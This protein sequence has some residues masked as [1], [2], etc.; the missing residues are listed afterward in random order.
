MHQA[1]STLSFR[2]PIPSPLLPTTRFLL[3]IPNTANLKVGGNGGPCDPL[4][5]GSC[6]SEIVN[7]NFWF[8]WFLTIISGTSI[9][10][11]AILSH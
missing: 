1:Q 6:L 5:K 10:I 7:Q 3:G 11:Y 8:G 4:T 9:M 2:T